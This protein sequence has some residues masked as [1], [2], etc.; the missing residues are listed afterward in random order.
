[1]NTKET[2]QKQLEELRNKWKIYPKSSLEPLWWKFKCDKLLAE[3]LKT[4]IKKIDLGIDL[5]TNELTDD[6]MAELLK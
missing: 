1:M 2:L 5:E 4:Q 6:Q 3:Q